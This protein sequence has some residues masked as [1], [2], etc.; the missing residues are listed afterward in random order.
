MFFFSTK[1]PMQ[2]YLNSLIAILVAY[3][4]AAT[5]ENLQQQI[6][7]PEN[8]YQAEVVLFTQPNNNGSETAP[9]QS[10]LTFPQ[11]WLQL[12]QP[13]HF[14]PLYS[15][16][17]ISTRSIANYRTNGS[18][19]P[20][21]IQLHSTIDTNTIEQISQQIEKSPLTT[22]IPEAS[23]PYKYQMPTATNSPDSGD[24]KNNQHPNTQEQPPAFVP[25]YEPPFVKIKRANRDLN[26]SARGLDR[27]G[28]NVLFHQ[29]WRFQIDSKQQ[30]P[31]ILIKAGPTTTGRYQIEGTVRFYKSRYLHFET[32]LWRLKFANNSDNKTLLLP[33]IPQTTI[34]DQQAV[35]LNAITFSNNL[36]ALAPT[37]I[38]QTDVSLFD[39]HSLY[40]LSSL[41]HLQIDKSTQQQPTDRIGYPISEV[42]PIAQ[43]KRLQK[44]EV[45]YI[46][47]PEVGAL[48]TIKPYMPELLNQPLASTE[49]TEDSAKEN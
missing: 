37:H 47:H 8:W 36:A 34:N 30:S 6:A 20:S 42:W 3:P 17:V 19:K 39:P 14:T 1:A 33:E 40:N 12:A 16:P 23:I 24:Y 46:D 22:H 25:V 10:K 44:N 5:T 49:I 2:R 35:L 13:E 9:L 18:A 7:P 45:Y 26:D 27:R 31:W 48:V 15:L 11:N 29:A 21:L 28:Y 4:I 32:D 38:Q 41:K 43:S